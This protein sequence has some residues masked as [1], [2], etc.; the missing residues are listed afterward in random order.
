MCNYV[1]LLSLRFSNH[2]TKRF[3]TILTSRPPKYANAKP[4][5]VFL[6]TIEMVLNYLHKDCKFPE[7][8]GES[9]VQ[10]LSDQSL[11]SRYN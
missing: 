7:F 8:Q 1:S 9:L 3:Q 11:Y 4:Y 5:Q 6:I 2:Q 10:I